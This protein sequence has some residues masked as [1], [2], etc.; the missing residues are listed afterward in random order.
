MNSHSS[1]L[2]GFAAAGLVAYQAK[3]ESPKLTI[4]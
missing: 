2:T 1:I 3:A 4:V